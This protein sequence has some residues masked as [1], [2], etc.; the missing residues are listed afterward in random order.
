VAYHCIN[1]APQVTPPP[2][3]AISTRSPSLI[4]PAST[5]SSS[6]IGIDAEEVFP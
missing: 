5:H 4:R 6:A 3:D 1:T 2:N